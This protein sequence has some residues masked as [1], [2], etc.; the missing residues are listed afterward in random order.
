V[1]ANSSRSDGAIAIRSGQRASRRF[2]V[3]EK[4]PPTTTNDSG[5]PAA[6]DEN[7]LTVGRGGPTVLHDAYVVQKMQ[8]F[9]ASAFPSA[10]STRRAAGRT[11]SSR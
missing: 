5:I 4:R 10:S 9:T 11:G 3:N 8:H 1:I 2:P 7:S 6:S